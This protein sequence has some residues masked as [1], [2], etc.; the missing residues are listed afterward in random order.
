[1]ALCWTSAAEARQPAVQSIDIAATRLPD[2]LAELAREAEVSIGAEGSL[3]SLRTVPVRGRM[4]VAQALERILAGSGYVARQVG[5][6]AWRIERAPQHPSAP[7]TTVPA[8]VA[9][10]EPIP[11]AIDTTPIMVTG[12]KRRSVL[13]QV[14]MAITV[15]Q[16]DPLRS[17]SPATGTSAI[18]AQSDGLAMTGLGPGRNRLFLRGVADSAFNGE[19]QSTVAVVFD[20]S[21]LTFSAPDPDIRLVDVDRVEVLKGPQGS[22][23]GTGAL[24]GIFHIVPNRAKVDESSL[25]GFVGADSVAHGNQG[26]SGSVAVNL[27]VVAGMV[28]LRLVGYGANEAGWVDT[29][30]R[31]DS[32]RSNLL[33]GR[34]NLGV[35]PGGG[36]RLDLSGLVQL[37]ESRDSSY[38]YAP[39]ARSRPAQ[40]PEPH[41]NDIRHLS[42][43]LSRQAGG[44]DITL[45]T[46]VTWHE[47]TDTLDATIGADS[48]ALADPSLYEDRR[49]Y[50]VWDSEARISGSAGKLRWLGGVSHLEAKQT[51]VGTL[52]S[53]SGAAIVLD[54]DRRNTTETALFGDVT[55]PVLPDL[56]IDAGGRLF[57]GSTRERRILASGPAEQQRSR[58]GFAPSLAISWQPQTGEIVYLRYASTYRQG[59][60]DISASGQFEMLKADELRTLELGWRRSFLGGG[61]IDASIYA[62]RWE[63]LQSDVLQ[64]NGLIESVNAGE[65]RIVGAE[66]SLELP[67]P[68]GF[69]LQ[70]G[71]AA[72]DARLVRNELGVSLDDR[73]LPVVPT[74]TVRGALRR[75]FRIGASN[76][77]VA[78]RL[79]Y[80]GPQ[81][82]S[83][84]PSIDR[85][86]GSYFDAGLEAQVQ[87]GRAEAFLTADNLLG[88]RKDD[89][90]FGNSLRFGTMRQYIPQR[91]P[92]VSVGLSTHF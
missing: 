32:N 29:G 22:L 86:M 54:D 68:H 59:G 67:L 80:V 37:L 14:P 70:A 79:R 63:N 9:R 8:P 33:G 78:L 45:S 91:P 48:F 50:R 64:S 71:A 27:P 13:S 74:F 75:D 73:R 72:T 55:L 84:D 87:L 5:P 66:L 21:R 88:S 35:V 38:V 6:T 26:Y 52:N 24:G 69:S 20:E 3:P 30:H 81:R 56:S 17:R 85:P 19:S 47:V 28:G 36:W 62:S 34:F 15:I 25:T 44:V 82:L 60:S 83:F 43:R 89:F 76:A 58:T 42:A 2:A 46:G 12:A 11:E 23:Y 40:L 57:R 92:S 51:A 39:E 53:F 10:T 90:A 65:A 4:S 49:F 61:R 41:D 1:M 16:L 18:A 7:A 77:S 31:P